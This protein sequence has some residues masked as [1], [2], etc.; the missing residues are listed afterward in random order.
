MK[1]VKY[2]AIPTKIGCLAGMF[3]WRGTLHFTSI[4]IDVKLYCVDQVKI[5]LGAL[6]G[7]SSITQSR[8]SITD[9]D[10]PKAT[11]VICSI[12]DDFMVKQ[13]MCMSCGSLGLGKEGQLISCTQCGQCYHPYCVDVRVRNIMLYINML[14]S[15]TESCFFLD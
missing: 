5:K 4:L 14:F 6:P 15:G 2:F 9:D 1:P 7:T 13:D 11:T 10:D 8:W 12:K 3:F